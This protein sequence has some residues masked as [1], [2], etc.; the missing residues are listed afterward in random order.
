MAVQSIMWMMPLPA[1]VCQHLRRQKYLRQLYASRII[2]TVSELV[3]LLKYCDKYVP[4]LRDKLIC[5]INQ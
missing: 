1:I 5:D 2:E 4:H 3:S